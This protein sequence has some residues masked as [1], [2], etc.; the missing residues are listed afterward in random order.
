MSFIEIAPPAKSTKPPINPDE[1][2]LTT[3][4]VRKCDMVLLRFGEIAIKRLKLHVGR[5]YMVRWGIDEHAGKLRLSEV[6]KGWE[7]KVPKRGNTAQITLSRLPQ[8]YLGRSFQAKKIT[9]EQIDGVQGRSD[10]FV[11]LVLPSDFFAEPEEDD[12]EQA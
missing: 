8:H 12:H 2:L 11:Q 10:P 5:Q 9:G 7:L 6:S 1:I 4:K 3:R